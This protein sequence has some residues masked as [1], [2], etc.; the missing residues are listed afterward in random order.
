MNIVRPAMFAAMAAVVTDAVPSNGLFA[1]QL[2]LK[3]G[4]QFACQ[5]LG[6]QSGVVELTRAI[7]AATAREWVRLGAIETI[8]APQPA[9]AGISSTQSWPD[10][11]ALDH[12]L[13]E[14][15]AATSL[16]R[17]FDGVKGAWFA[18]SA[19]V[20][21]FLLEKSKHYADALALLRQLDRHPDLTNRANEI[22][23]R[24]AVLTWHTK[25]PD[26][27]CA[28]LDA[29]LPRAQTDAARAELS[30][31]RGIALARLGR[32]ADSLFSLLRVPVFYSH[33]GDWERTCLVA[34]L[35]SFA[36]LGQRDEFEKACAAL[37]SD[38]PGSPQAAMGSNVLDRLKA[39]LPLA[40]FTSL[41]FYAKEP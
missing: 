16:W 39:G 9:I 12:A 35:P 8:V 38:F 40:S 10:A 20:Q 7:G 22:A 34:A 25:G 11:F 4:R 33:E 36:A 31:C 1:A 14:A 17:P 41:T 19:L 3:D 5:V 29:A 23:V 32:P 18:S 2:R 21:V 37:V 6:C 15:K 27:A 13:A 28:A 30:Y 24:Q 26:T